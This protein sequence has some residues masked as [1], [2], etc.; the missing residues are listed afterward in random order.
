[1]I[2]A[3]LAKSGDV[4]SSGMPRAFHGDPSVHRKDGTGVSPTAGSRRGPSRP[5]ADVLAAREHTRGADLRCGRDRVTRRSGAAFGA[6]S[7]ARERRLGDRS[8]CL[9]LVAMTS[10]CA[11]PVPSARI[12]PGTCGRLPMARVVIRK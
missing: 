9:G 7:G 8:I 6:R 2:S 10:F 12:E 3:A 1:V 11:P 4:E 5:A